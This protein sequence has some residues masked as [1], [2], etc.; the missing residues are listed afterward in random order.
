FRVDLSAVRGPV[1]AGD[2]VGVDAAATYLFGAPV[3][4]GRIAWSLVRAGDAPYPERWSRFT[5]VPAGTS[6]GHGTVAAGEEALGA[7]G[8]LHLDAPA[9]LGARVRTAMALE[10]EVTDGA[11]HTQAAR[12]SFVVYPSGV[13]VGVRRGDDWVALGTPIAV[14]A[15]AIDHDGAPVEGAAIDARIVR[16]GW[17]SW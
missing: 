1:H 12:R 13:E 17:H 3:T 7:S 15:I 2:V 6:A 16:E 11:G 10:A 4:S 5:F 14:E 8:E 9:Q